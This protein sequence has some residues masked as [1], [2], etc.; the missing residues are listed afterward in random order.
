MNNIRIKH[1]SPDPNCPNCHGT[2]SYITGYGMTSLQSS[3]CPCFM[4]VEIYQT[5]EYNNPVNIK[6]GWDVT[7]DLH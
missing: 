2:G 7:K 6:V 1:C 3:E 4:R 5:P